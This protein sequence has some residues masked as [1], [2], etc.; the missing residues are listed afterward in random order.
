M[1]LNTLSLKKFC[2]ICFL[3]PL[4]LLADSFSFSKSKSGNLDGQYYYFYVYQ[5]A[6][7]QGDEVL[8]ESHTF[9]FS[10]LLDGEE[11]AVLLGKADKWLI[12]E[13][14]KIFFAIPLIWN[15]KIYIKKKKF[16]DCPSGKTN[17]W[18]PISD[19][20]IELVNNN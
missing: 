6:Y 16:L 2:L 5:Y 17:Q 8:S 15:E 1:K 19:N 11:G 20:D 9:T 12:Y 14:K 10:G 7:W 18:I 3:L 4:F 13:G